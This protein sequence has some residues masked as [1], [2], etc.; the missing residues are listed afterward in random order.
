M[1]AKSSTRRVKIIFIVRNTASIES[2]IHTLEDVLRSASR[3]AQF[4]DISVEVYETRSFGGS[5][6]SSAAT[7]PGLTL[8]TPTSATTPGLSLLTPGLA[9]TPGLRS[10]L[11]KG[12]IHSTDI[13]IIRGQRPNLTTCLNHAL[14]DTQPESRNETGGGVALISCGPMQLITSVSRSVGSEESKT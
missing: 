11:V 12:E 10:P 5:I 7:T 13:R 1:Q 4:L 9:M 6:T 2:F 14:N 3:V 8:F